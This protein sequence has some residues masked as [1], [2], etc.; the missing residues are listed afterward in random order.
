MDRA[1][2]GQVSNRVQQDVFNY[3]VPTTS[4]IYPYA[5]TWRK[6]YTCTSITKK[7]VPVATS[8]SRTYSL[9][10]PPPL[11]FPCIQNILPRPLRNRYRRP[12]PGLGRAPCT[13]GSSCRRRPQLSQAR[14]TARGPSPEIKEKIFHNVR[15]L[16]PM[17]CS[18][19]NS[20]L[21]IRTNP[22]FGALLKYFI[23]P[24]NV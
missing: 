21:R 11:F 19:L 20:M 10:Y 4:A 17:P 5:C 14:Y 8:R 3:I 2:P 23:Y 22:L 15:H 13:W 6:S 7:P 18:F 1:L 24:K 16:F 12:R 9:G